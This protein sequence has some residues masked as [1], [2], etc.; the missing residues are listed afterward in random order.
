MD[1]NK[2]SMS[3]TAILNMTLLT[4]GLDTVTN[5]SA[6]QIPTNFFLSD[7]ECPPPIA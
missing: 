3:C 5:R 7:V 1:D 2:A 4:S 6:G